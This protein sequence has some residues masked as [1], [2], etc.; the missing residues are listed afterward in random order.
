MQQWSRQAWRTVRPAD[1]AG[2]VTWYGG[3]AAIRRTSG[4]SGAGARAGSGTTA[5]ARPARSR[6]VRVGDAAGCAE[7]SLGAGAE[8]TR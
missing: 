3:G 2:Q 6:G 5:T 7:W 1:P 4:G 8:E